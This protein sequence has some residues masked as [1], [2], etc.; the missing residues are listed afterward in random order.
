[1]LTA[2]LATGSVV[3]AGAAL[4]GTQPEPVAPAKPAALARTAPALVG[5]QIP[6]P[7]TL[8]TAVTGTWT[9]GASGG[10]VNSSGAGLFGALTGFVPS[11][12]GLTSAAA[13]TAR[14]SSNASVPLA[15]AGATPTGERLPSAVSDARDRIPPAFA[16]TQQLALIG[17]TDL[18][19]A[20]ILG[21]PAQIQANPLNMIGP[22]AGSSATP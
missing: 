13:S 12:S 6:T 7:N 21:L 3:A 8:L 14:T 20:R 1:M 22:G 4:A 16:R 18:V 15:L 10:G 11:A 2:A 17:N 19:L 5:L 9:T